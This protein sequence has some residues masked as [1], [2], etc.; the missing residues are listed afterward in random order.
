MEN[1]EKEVLKVS[2]INNGTVLDHIPS[3][4]LFRVIDILRL[5]QSKTPITF[6][7]NLDSKTLGSKAIIKRTADRY[8]EITVASATPST[9]IWNPMTKIRFAMTLTTPEMIR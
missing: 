2:A 4:Q 6:G 9:V 8:C 1:R 5:N 7:M 3:A